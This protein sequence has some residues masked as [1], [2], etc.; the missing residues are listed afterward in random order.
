MTESDLAAA[1]VPF[2]IISNRYLGLERVCFH[3][4]GR[5]CYYLFFTNPKDING[6]D[7]SVL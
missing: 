1:A 4:G 2:K 6:K 5:G 7:A 3:L